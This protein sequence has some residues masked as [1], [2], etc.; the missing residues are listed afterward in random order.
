[1]TRFEI[2]TDTA[3]TVLVDG[4]DELDAVEIATTEGVL[5]EGDAGS[6]TSY[7]ERPV[8]WDGVDPEEPDVDVEHG[9]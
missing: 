8:G 7:D 5:T 3:L 2:R 6:V 9:D 1:M 4:T